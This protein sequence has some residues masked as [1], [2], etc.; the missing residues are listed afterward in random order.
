V[1]ELVVLTPLALFFSRVSRHSLG[2]RV[3]SR[4]CMLPTPPTAINIDS[5]LLTPNFLF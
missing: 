5:Q 2:T 3:L 4:G 1:S